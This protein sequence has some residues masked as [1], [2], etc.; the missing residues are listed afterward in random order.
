[1]HDDYG[2]DGEMTG[3]P[4]LDQEFYQSPKRDFSQPEQRTD[5]VEQAARIRAQWRA[6]RGAK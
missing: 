3:D 6:R 2:Y 1:M 4:T 5:Y